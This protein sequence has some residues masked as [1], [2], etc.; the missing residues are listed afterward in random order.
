MTLTDTTG[1]FQLLNNG[2]VLQALQ[3]AWRFDPVSGDLQYYR[4]VAQVPGWES[5]ANFD[6]TGNPLAAFMTPTAQGVPAGVQVAGILAGSGPVY[7]GNKLQNGS[8]PTFE[9]ATLASIFPT[10]ATQSGDTTT[11][12][13]DA[14]T[15][16]KPAAK[17]GVAIAVIGLAGLAWF[18]FGGHK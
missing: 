17:V 6:K 14:P 11:P 16:T 2:L 3:P 9:P 7:V 15:A 12:T 8:V 5:E 1:R 10:L 18:A 13:P 4:S